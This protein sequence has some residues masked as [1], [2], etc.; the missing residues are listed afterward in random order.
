MRQITGTLTHLRIAG[1]RGN[2]SGKDVAMGGQRRAFQVVR[3][4]YG[5]GG[6]LEA[7]RPV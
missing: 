6:I 2:Y 3:T 5:Y 4:A 7:I 1:H